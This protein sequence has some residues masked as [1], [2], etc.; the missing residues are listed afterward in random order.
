MDTDMG[1]DYRHAD[2]SQPLHNN[3]KAL[4]VAIIAENFLPKIDGSTTTLAHLL[5]HLA[6]TRSHAMLFGPGSGMRE[7]ARAALFGTFGVPLRVYPGLKIKV[8][9]VFLPSYPPS[10]YTSYTP[11]PRTSSISS[12]IWL[13]VQALIALQPLFP[14]APIVSSHHTNFLT[15]AEI[16]G[17][18]ELASSSL[19]PLSRSFGVARRLRVLSAVSRGGSG[20]ETELPAIECTPTS[21]TGLGRFTRICTLSRGARYT[22]VPSPSTVRLLRAKGWG[23]SRVVGRGVDGGGD[24]VH[25]PLPSLRASWDASGPADVVFHSV[26]RLSPKKNLGLV[27]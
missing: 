1:M 14:S 21:T 5:Q 26:D 19:F 20:F 10:S 27:V 17:P 13:G 7:Y 8:R 15:Y 3:S 6:A 22:L 16:F 9:V 12:T 11:S 23:N 24:F 25:A 4:R 18:Y 2:L